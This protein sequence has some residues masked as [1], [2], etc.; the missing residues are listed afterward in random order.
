VATTF[1]WTTPEAITSAL[2]TELNSL[3]NAAYSAASAAI[4]NS[5]GLYEWM[6]LELHLASLTPTG[7]PYIQ[8]FLLPVIDTVYEDGGGA[9]APS[10]GTLICTWDLSTSVGAKQR[11][12]AGILIPPFDFKLALLNQAGP[13][14][15]A[16]LNTLKYRRYNEQGV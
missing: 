13:A 1:Q 7:S 12:K 16:T 15:G 2:T 10:N 4:T 3:A 9:V 6:A 8:V 14:L 11:T 5:S